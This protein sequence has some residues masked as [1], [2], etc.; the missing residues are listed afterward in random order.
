MEREA[1]SEEC[2]L[3]SERS[4]SAEPTPELEPIPLTAEGIKR[5]ATQLGDL[6]REPLT[7]EAWEI[8]IASEQDKLCRMAQEKMGCYALVPLQ[9]GEIRDGIDGDEDSEPITVTAEG[10]KRIATQFGDLTQGPLTS[11]AWEVLIASEQDKLCR[12]VQEKMGW[13][14]LVPLL[15]IGVCE[16]SD[17]DDE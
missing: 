15:E 10:I 4:G 13:Y 3:R 8:L 14:A 16:G 5:I 9:E 7:S 12:M 11:E 1:R 2:G 6:S 17:G